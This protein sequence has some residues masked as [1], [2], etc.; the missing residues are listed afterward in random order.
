MSF[1][2][3]PPAWKRSRLQSGN[4]TLMIALAAIGI[5]AIF[6]IGLTV[7]ILLLSQKRSQNQTEELALKLSTQLNKDNWTGN[8]NNLV[9]FSRELVYSSRQDLDNI[10][11]KHPRLKPL[12]IQLLEESRQAALLVNE[13][14]KNLILAELKELKKSIE[15]QTSS[16][17]SANSSIS[18]PLVNTEKPAVVI[19]DAGY[20]E[21]VPSNVYL[22]EGIPELNEFDIQ[23]KYAKASSKVFDAGINARLPAPDDDLEF[24]LAS[25]P[26]PAKGTIAPARLAANNVFRKI[27]TVMPNTEANLA[28]CNQLPSAVQIESAV[29]VSS[30][31]AKDAA[32]G[33]IKLKVTSAA[34]GATL[35]LP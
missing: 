32:K 2:S 29:V 4:M 21:G 22:S 10:T 19:V 15:K 11:S 1:D 3:N 16:T 20:L 12:A 8:M 24:P 17:A 34:P 35:T 25:L 9:G 33:A 6:A 5:V 7:S 13:E 23:A 31:A 27:I 30:P 18:L 14:R 28:K 26:A